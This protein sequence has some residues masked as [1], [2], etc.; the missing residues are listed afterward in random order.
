MATSI[1]VNHIGLAVADLE[2]AR[3]FWTEAFDFRPVLELEPPDGPTS[4]LL[5]V[6]APVGLR[7]I[8]LRRDDFVLELLHFSAAGLHAREPRVMNE[9]GLTHLSLLV[10]DLEARLEKV[11]EL[12][13]TVV[14]ESRLG[15]A[16]VLVLDPDG[17]RVELLTSWEKPGAPS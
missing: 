6:A 4:Q 10:D 7:A 14:E 8:Y 2:R 17:Q 5:G 3:R 11:R 9:P 16:A 15:D 12:G 1:R 13:G